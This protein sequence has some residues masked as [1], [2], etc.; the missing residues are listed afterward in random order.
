MKNTAKMSSRQ[1]V[2]SRFVKANCMIIAIYKK[3]RE[4]FPIEVKKVLKSFINRLMMARF[5]SFSIVASIIG[6]HVKNRVASKILS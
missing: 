3:L 4:N 5:R 1:L 6:L 2:S